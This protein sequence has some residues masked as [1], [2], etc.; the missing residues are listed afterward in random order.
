LIEKGKKG[1]REKRQ[2]AQVNGHLSDFDLPLFIVLDIEWASFVYY[3]RPW[4]ECK[5]WIPSFSLSAGPFSLFPFFPFSFRKK[6]L[7]Q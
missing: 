1:K 7:T 2:T 6:P 4:S 5:T 3:G